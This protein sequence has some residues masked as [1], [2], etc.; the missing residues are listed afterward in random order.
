VTDSLPRLLLLIPVVIGVPVLARSGALGSIE[1]LLCG[2]AA[3]AA[4]M[5]LASARML[6]PRRALAQEARQ[7]VPGG[8][9]GGGEWAQ[10]S[11]CLRSLGRQRERDR[12]RIRELE[13]RLHRAQ[14]AAE[15]A[16]T[17]KRAFLANIGHDIR[18]PMNVVV[19]MTRLSLRLATSQRQR[20]YLLRA[21]RAAQ[22]LLTQL[23]NLLDLVRL[24]AGELRVQPS[25]FSASELLTQVI[26][27]QT[28]RA[29]RKRLMLHLA[30]DTRVPP[31]VV[32]DPDRLRQVIASLLDNAVK[33]TD[34]GRIVVACRL[35]A[36][37]Q[38]QAR[39]CFEVRHTDVGI[40]LDK[41][42]FLFERLPQGD[43][44]LTR[45]RGGAGLG[46]TLC[47]RLVRAMGGAL[48]LDSEP[49]MGWSFRVE[50]PFELPASTG[51]EAK[52]PARAAADSADAA[53]AAAPDPRR[54]HGPTRLRLRG[55]GGMLH[56]VLTRF[57]L[58]HATFVED[59][60]SLHAAGDRLGAAQLART[61][62]S[63]AAAL[64]ALE[65]GAA[66]SRLALKRRAD[67]QPRADLKHVDDL[68]Q[69]L[70][71]EIDHRPHASADAAPP[72]YEQTDAVVAL[73]TAAGTM[74]TRSRLGAL[75]SELRALAALLADFD[76]GAI[77]AFES[78]YPHLAAL[79]PAATVDAL[80][81]AINGFDFATAGELL[82]QVAGHLGVSLQRSK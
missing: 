21:D 1:G 12:A 35:R 69:E 81:T 25:A 76:A 31:V 30:L 34:V 32:G 42:H 80:Q 44:T 13:A 65:L 50:L 28:E 40:A 17:A 51:A 55:D 8:A 67:D 15:S 70:L 7:L 72:T 73:D 45:R 6:G 39:L 41:Q 46:L 75:A 59:Y 18:T 26:A 19:G 23:G 54:G 4:L 77:N 62:E 36:R 29:E 63:A 74:P 64:G 9:D 79:A 66:A 37:T 24:E 43:A 56:R 38:R 3:L 16:D 5:Y 68:L 22:G 14:A 53:G 71:D 60:S 58:E 52:R 33:F 48:Q 10:I 27:A 11:A 57:R 82:R 20:D 78:L 49:G 2:T 47:Q 61:L